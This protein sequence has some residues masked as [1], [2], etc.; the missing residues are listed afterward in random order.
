MIKKFLGILFLIYI[1]FI[2]SV[3]SSEESIYNKIDLFGEELEKINI[4]YVD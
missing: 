1:S 3:N 2:Q 4:E